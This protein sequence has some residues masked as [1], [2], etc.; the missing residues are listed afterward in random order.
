MC[1]Y[2]HVIVQVASRS[3]STSGTWNCQCVTG[4]EHVGFCHHLW[5]PDVTRP[6]LNSELES[7][8]VLF[9]L[10]CQLTVDTWLPLASLPL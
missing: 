1:D 6:F 4:H 2:V 10:H 5:V 9:S 3:V 7:P 8:Q